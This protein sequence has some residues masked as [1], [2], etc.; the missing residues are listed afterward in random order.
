V[1]FQWWSQVTAG[2]TW[3]GGRSEA[4]FQIRPAHVRQTH[5]EPR[6]DI[7]DDEPTIGRV[8]GI[9]LWCSSDARER[10]LVRRG[11]QVVPASDCWSDL[12]FWP[13]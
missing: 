1:E 11:V 13:Q 9:L 8:R 12:E 5:G 2:P 7:I 6:R 4:A 10:Q 3:S